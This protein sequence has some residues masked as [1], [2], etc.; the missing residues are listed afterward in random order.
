MPSLK[1]EVTRISRWIK[2]T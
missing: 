2:V 1:R